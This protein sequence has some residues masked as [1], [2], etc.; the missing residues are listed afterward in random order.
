[1][2]ELQL[3]QV[4]D[5]ATITDHAAAHAQILSPLLEENPKLTMLLSGGSAIQ[6]Y[7]VLV[8]QYLKNLLDGVAFG[9]IDER[10]VK[11]GASTSNEAQL[12]SAGVLAEIEAGGASFTGMIHAGNYQEN[13]DIIQQQYASL[14]ER[15]VTI[16]LL[17]IGPD[18]HTAGILPTR[19]AAR[20]QQ[21]YLN[22]ELITYYAVDPQDSDN[23]HRHRYTLVP[24]A[25]HA[26]SVIVVYAM[27]TAKLPVLERLLAAAQQIRL[28]RNEEQEEHI[29]EQVHEMPALELLLGTGRLVIISD[30]VR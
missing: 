6:M 15:A 3:I 5:T 30:Q 28:L 1:M 16:G 18:G 8:R 11:P 23:E 13:V 24:D 22:K 26:L 25:L 9:L 7:A 29:H 2:R 12:V 4:S 21:L 20:Y 14:M 27:G 17:G 10:V 19:S